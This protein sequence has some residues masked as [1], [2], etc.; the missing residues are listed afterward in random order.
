MIVTIFKAFRRILGLFKSVYYNPFAKLILTLNGVQYGK[1]LKVKG[2]LKV[3]VTRRGKVSL[4]TNVAINSGKNHNIIGRQQKTTFWVEGKLKIGDN[5]GMSA[6]AI[7][8]NYDIEI[9]NNVNLGGNTVIYDTDFHALDPKIR[10][11]KTRD[12]NEAKKAKV[13][14][15]D[16]VFIGSHSTILKGVTI[17]NNS[18]IGACSLVSKN[19][20][21]NEIWGGNPIKFIKKIE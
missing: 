2:F 12:K 4:G 3:F 19:I 10:L 20:P 9:G 14:V 18:V 11:D 7:I 17:G 16:N 15:G 5:T 21:A 8:C 13:I 6:T 1:G